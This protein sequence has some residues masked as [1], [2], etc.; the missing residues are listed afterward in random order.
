M[1]SP[2]RKARSAERFECWHSAGAVARR[3][4]RGHY[5]RKPSLRFVAPS[6]SLLGRP[7]WWATTSHKDDL[8]ARASVFCWPLQLAGDRTEVVAEIG[9]YQC[10]SGDRCDCNQCGNQRELKRANNRGVPRGNPGNVG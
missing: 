10:E 3:R 4:K 8:L 9:A 6:P 1:P 7:C 5:M 2:C